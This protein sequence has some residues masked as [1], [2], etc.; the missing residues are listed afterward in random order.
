[1]LQHD[2]A[3]ANANPAGL[4]ED[5]GNGQLWRRT[6]ELVSIV[7]FGYPEAMIAPGFRL[8]RKR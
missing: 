7:V 5:P 1:M 4:A 2:A 8:L 3:G 6:G